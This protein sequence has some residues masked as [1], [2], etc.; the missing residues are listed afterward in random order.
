MKDKF[1]EFKE[2]IIENCREN[3]IAVIILLLLWAFAVPFTLYFYQDSLGKISTGNE[4]F[5]NVVELADGTVVQQNLPIVEGSESLAIK[6]ATYAR[7]NNGSFTVRVSG[8]DSGII[9]ADKQVKVSSLQDNAFMTFRL[10]EK[11][12]PKNDSQIRVVLS[13]D[14]QSGQGAGVYYSNLKAYEDGKLEINGQLQE[15]D[16]SLRFLSESKELDLFYRIVIIWVI[17]TFTL[18]ILLILLVKP[19]YE[20]LFTV[21]AICFGLTFWL[22]ITPMS[23][24]DETI[25]YEYSLQLSNYMMGK[26]DHLIID[27]EYQNYGAMAGHLNIS[28]AYER[29]ITKINRP[30]HLDNKDSK[31]NFDIDES[32]KICFVPQ[33]LGITLARL[34]NWNMLRTFYLG[35]LFNLIFYVICVYI[36]IKKTPVHKLLFGILATLPIFMQQAASFSYD[37][38]INGLTFVIIGCLMKWMHQKEIIDLKEFVFVFIVNMLIAPI[39]VVYGL[40]SF[41]YWFV[42]EENFGKKKDKIIGALIITAPA[43]YELTVLL[44]PLAFRIIRKIF[45]N[46]FLRELSAETFFVSN[47]LLVEGDT[48]TFSDVMAHPMEAIELLLRTIRYSLKTWFYA[49]FGRALSGNTL[50]LP[51]YLVHSLLA[52]IV[53]SA[54]LEEKH[55]GSFTFRFVILI[56]CCFAGLMMVGGM[57]IS[58]TEVDQEIIEDYGGPIIQG[59]QGRYF[60][61]FLPYLFII[62]NNSR[63]KIS[64]KC[65]QYILYAFV[66]LVF[67]VVVYVLSYTFM[68]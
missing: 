25:H 46:L 66:V 15:G 11:L 19:K 24:P 52:L 4:A 27:E 53:L 45:E 55:T 43:M 63:L 39:K 16:L 31:M 26:K 37:C 22:I 32:Y 35:R 33:A 47:P 5:D 51:T 1:F 64:R 59:I 21:I 6:F 40:F 7:R 56:M 9:Y 38:Y 12:D 60:S 10:S 18:I 54:L 50:I 58:W 13:S 8:I 36:A 68:N 34:L 57:L 14:S 29:F 49:S 67:E 62:I 23:V 48:Y 30:M 41:L 61:P 2:R 28:A 3:K 42:P 65:D 17:S 44:F 20:V